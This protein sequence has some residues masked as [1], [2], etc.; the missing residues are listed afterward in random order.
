MWVKFIRFGR[1]PLELLL[2]PQLVGHDQNYDIELA[3][4]R[5]MVARSTDRQSGSTLEP[6]DVHEDHS[7]LRNSRCF[8]KN[9]NCRV[10]ILIDHDLI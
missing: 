2:P 5:G 4:T 3:G 1:C 6:R 8:R 9:E 10:L 7:E